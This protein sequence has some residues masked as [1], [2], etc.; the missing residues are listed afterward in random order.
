MLHGRTLLLL[1]LLAEVGHAD[2]LTVAVASNFARPA[3]EL[4]ERFEKTSGHELRITTASTGKLYAQIENGAPFD[5]LL[6]ADKERPLLLE[7]S[8]LGVAGSRFTYAVGSLVLWSRDPALSNADC[9]AQ[10]DKLGK[11]RLA[12]ANPATAPYGVAALQFLQAAGAWEAVQPRLVFGEN[13]AQ[14]LHFVASG[15]ASLGLI[16]TAQARDARLP[17]STCH[18]PVPR[19]MHEA[20]EHQVILLER[21]S[22]KKAA[23]DFLAYLRTGDARDVITANGYEMDN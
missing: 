3:H 6:A 18:W 16:A 21:A 13:I 19:S 23:T 22:G 20:L 8:G 4:A 7:E 14:T 17:E 11:K 2:S 1:L 12:I 15:N 5:I 10:L 9:R